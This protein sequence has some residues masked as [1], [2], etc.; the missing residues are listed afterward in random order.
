MVDDPL[1][2]EFAKRVK[3]VFPLSPLPKKPL[4]RR[5][6]IA[7]AFRGLRWNQV[8]PDILSRFCFELHDLY[9]HTYRYYLPAFLT[10]ILL[11]EDEVGSLSHNMLKYSLIPPDE[12][13]LLYPLFQA[14]VRGL[15][16]EQRAVIYELFA[17]HSVLFPGLFRDEWW[18]GPA[19]NDAEILEKAL[20][21]WGEGS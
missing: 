21:F 14:E 18:P 4:A 13:D 11:H 19:S 12:D 6:R 20:K 16:R 15:T 8:K 1:N 2:V 10:G 9:P 3:E 17:N 7:D 5:E